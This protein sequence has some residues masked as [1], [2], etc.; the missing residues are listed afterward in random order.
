MRP[1]P[2]VSTAAA[3]NTAPTYAHVP[4]HHERQDE[5]DARMR[6]AGPPEIV[7]QRV[8]GDARR[9]VYDSSQQH[10][11]RAAVQNRTMVD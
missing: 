8:V 9:A 7:P 11:N 1:T 4:Q 5:I 6:M 3:K 2:S 10:D